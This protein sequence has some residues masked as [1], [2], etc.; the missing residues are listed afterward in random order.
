M[1]VVVVVGCGVEVRGQ[2][3]ADVKEDELKSW[4]MAA[5][6]TM[7]FMALGL[8]LSWL[9]QQQLQHLWSPTTIII[10]I[11]ISEEEAV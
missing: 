10:T 7:H 6:A 9:N 5:M 11:I 4:T 8:L 3:K 2:R 1:V